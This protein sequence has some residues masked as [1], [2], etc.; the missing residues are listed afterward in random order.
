LLLQLAALAE[1]L[2]RDCRLAGCSAMSTWVELTKGC[3]IAV[4]CKRL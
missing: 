4:K 1:L 2:A 3:V